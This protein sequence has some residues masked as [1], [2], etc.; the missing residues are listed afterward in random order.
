MNVGKLLKDEIERVSRK[1]ARQHVAPVKGAALA[2]RKQIAALKK[3][4]AELSGQLATLRRAAGKSKPVPPVEG[5]NKHR[6]VAKGLITLRARLGLSAED[7]GRLVGAS[8]ASVYSWE[9][10]KTAP[11][12]KN[13]A[14]IAA[15]R[16]VGKREV[17]R[18]L[19]ELGSS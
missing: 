4:V 19:A 14:A 7:F 2:Q 18:R 6:F 15:L 1:V 11:K 8:G 12:P 10:K 16:G 9:H 17:Q 13:V 3:Q 5:G